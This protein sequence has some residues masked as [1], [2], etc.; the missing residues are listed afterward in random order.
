LKSKKFVDVLGLP[1]LQ[2]VQDIK[3]SGYQ[4]GTVIY[5]VAP[6]KQQEKMGNPRVVR[7][8]LTSQDKVDL[9]LASCPWSGNERG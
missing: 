6:K 8:R 1:Y 4:V 5:T 7:Q 2:A 3:N 9:V